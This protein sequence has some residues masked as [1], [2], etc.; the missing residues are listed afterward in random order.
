VE[1]LVGC[2]HEADDTAGGIEDLDRVE[3]GAQELDLV[4]QRRGDV[5]TSQSTRHTHSLVNR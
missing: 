2:L 4:P 5:E 3:I 1:E